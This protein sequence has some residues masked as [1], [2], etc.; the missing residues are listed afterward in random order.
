MTSVLT[1]DQKV[2]ASSLCLPSAPRPAA[3]LSFPALGAGPEE[4]GPQRLLGLLAAQV[5]FLGTT[6]VGGTAFH[7]HGAVTEDGCSWA[8]SSRYPHPVEE[9]QTQRWE[10]TCPR[11]H[12]ESVRLSL[13]GPGPGH[14]HFFW[15]S[16]LTGHQIPPGHAA[17]LPPLFPPRREGDKAVSCPPPPARRPPHP[18]PGP[19]TAG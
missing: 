13:L 4:K 7:T 8:T 6:G 16:V 17:L 15:L 11:P 1:L 3:G 5:L 14:L 19:S 2:R 10:D 18:P 12:G 9:S